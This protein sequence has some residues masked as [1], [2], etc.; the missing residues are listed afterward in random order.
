MPGRW[1]ASA[2]WR[3]WLALTGAIL[4]RLAVPCLHGADSGTAPTSQAAASNPGTTS[5]QSD[6]VLPRSSTRIR[7][8]RAKDIS[9]QPTK[10]TLSSGGFNPD[11][12]AP[13]YRLNFNNIVR[14]VY[15][16]TPTVRASREEMM[17]GKHAL[18]EFRANLSRLEPYVE[19]RSD[20]SDF[21]NRRGAF[22]NRVESVVGVKKERFE[23]AVLSTEVGASHSRFEFLNSVES[24]AGARMR[25]RVEVPFFGSRRR[26]DRI[27]AQ[28][29]QDST[30]RKA[31]LDYLKNFRAQVELA[32]SYYNQ[33]VFWQQVL[34]SN[35]QWLAAL[36][37]LLRDPRLGEPDR[38]RIETARASVESNWNHVSSRQD[39]NFGTLLAH[40]GGVSAQDVQV[41]MPDYR[42]MPLVEEAR[43]MEGLRV[44]IERARINN[45][46]FRILKDAIENAR[47]Q[48]QQAVR[49]RYDVT[50]FLEGTVFPV[51]S[52]S[53]DDRYRG[54]TVGGGLNV[55]MNDRS[56][57][58]STRMKSEARIRQFEAEIE[59]EEISIQEKINSNTTTIRNN[60]HNRRQMLDAAGRLKSVFEARREEYFA[61][62]VNIDQLLSARADI[63][64]NEGSLASNFQLTAERGVLLALAVGEVYELV[65]LRI[66]AD[67]PEGTASPEGASKPNPP[68]PKTR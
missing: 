11:N 50:T 12:V 44:L 58:D 20:L 42:V 24:G 47:L 60:D 53:F 37:L 26:Q 6:G 1:R 56:V 61:G 30:A 38:L 34:E 39:D 46:T 67:T 9:D 54:W 23:G 52:Q 14:I 62:T 31:Q 13:P 65:G 35:E 7:F 40:L 28:A 2:A 8:V 57:L 21:P 45:P 49:G 25:T 3:R 68:I 22:G 48:R 4:L 63:A 16:K 59:T 15:A 29:F 36:D 66:D 51:G 32:M 19:F 5:G 18:A 41:E 17:A 55:R 27:I 10:T 33:L 43:Q 64:S